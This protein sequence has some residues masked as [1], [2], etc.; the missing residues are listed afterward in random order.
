M[1][2][3][4]IKYKSGPPSLSGLTPIIINIKLT[5][6]G[7]EASKYSLSCVEICIRKNILQLQSRTEFNYF[8][9]ILFLGYFLVKF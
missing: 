5:H 2:K 6:L 9:K 8:G 1:I 3:F 7:S 4:S